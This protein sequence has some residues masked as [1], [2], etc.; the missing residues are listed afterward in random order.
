M[1]LTTSDAGS[2]PVHDRPVLPVPENPLKGESVALERIEAVGTAE[3]VRQQAA[4]PRQGLALALLVACAFMLNMDS[5]IVEVA[6]PS[7]RAD[8]GLALRGT[9]WVANS[10]ILAFG[11]FLLLGGRLG[12]L[13][14]RRRVFVYGLALFAVASLVGGMSS[15]PGALIGARVGQGLAAAVVAP[16]V[17]SL[18]ITVFPDE[19]P[20]ARLRRNKALSIMGALSAGGGS[21]GYFLGGTLTDVWGWQ[22]TFLVNVPIAAGAALAA[23]RFL[24]ETRPGLGGKMNI[25]GALAISV[26]MTGVV[27]VFVDANKAG[28][29]SPPTL[30]LSVLS[31]GILVGFF[32]AQKRSAEP[33]IPLRLFRSRVLR[34]ANTVAALINM[35]I[36][37]VILFVSFYVQDVLDYS[38]LAAGLA[39]MPIV[40]TVTV[41]STMTGWL[42]RHVSK[43]ALMNTGLAMFAC[44][45]A[46]MSQMSGGTYWAELL[47]P[48]CLVGFGGGLVFVTFTVSGTSDLDE[49][50][51]GLA[52]GVLTTSQK[53]GASFGLAVLITLADGRTERSLAG[54]ALS[55]REALTAGY[56]SAILA[57]IVPVLL[58]MVAA[59]VWVPGRRQD[60][61][62]TEAFP[63]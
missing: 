46:W 9:S 35:A 44:G 25:A 28:W 36:G 12:D 57:A 6:L 42:L 7:I 43:R 52:S 54:G 33:L 58:A 34:G 26:G 19:G 21:A 27:Y 20:E 14:G 17:L 11:G 24:P 29:T 1:P 55:S 39:I 4:R 15:S 2:E 13:F 16:S 62:R 3:A 38:A 45:L 10:Y 47:G 61:A 40:L 23:V 60:R 22:S 49:R 48:E 5:A 41:S 8:F 37:P 63:A 30:F 53:I 50:D 56:Q 59:T 51:A 18:L 31:L 32:V